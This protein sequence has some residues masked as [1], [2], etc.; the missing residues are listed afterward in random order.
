MGRREEDAMPD[1]DLVGRWRERKMPL[2]DP[3]GA[4]GGTIGDIYVDAQTGQPE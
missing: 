1:L 2:V 4:K 3:D